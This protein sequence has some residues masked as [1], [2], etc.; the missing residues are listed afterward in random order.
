MSVHEEELRPLSGA[1]EGIWFAQRL[2][3]ANGAYNTGEYVEIHGRIDPALFET[4]LR[5]TVAEAQTF[6][7]RFRD[8]PDG[9]C[10]VLPAEPADWP[11]HRVD[12]SAEPDP[13]AAAEEWIRADLAAAVDL[14]SGPLFT[15][16]LFTLGADHYA[17]S[18]RAHHILLDGYS[19]KLVARRLAETYS[20]L[21]AGGEVPPDPFGPIGPLLEADAEYRSSERFARHRAYWTDRLADA[22]A[23]VRLSGRTAPPVHSFRRRATVLPD[24][25]GLAAAAG[26]FGASRTDLLVAAVAAYLHRATGAED[27]VLGLATMSRL[28]SAALRTPGTTS[29]ILPLRV[30]VSPG[31]TV[32]DLVRGVAAEL[33]ALRRNQLYRG[34]Y[35]RRDLGLLDGGRR[36]YGPVVNLI[37]FSEDLRF[38]GHPSTS[39]HLTG[40]AVEDLQINVRPAEDGPGLWLAFD[41]NPAAYTEQELTA[42]Q[43]RFVHLLD[44]LATAEPGLPLARTSLLLPHEHR[45]LPE[46]APAPPLPAALTA[47]ARGTLPARFEEQAARAPQAPAVTDEHATLTYAELNDRA[48]RLARLLAA[49]GAGPGRLVALALPRTAELVTAVLAVLKTGAGYLPL[50]PAQPAERLRLVTEDAA[51]LLTV[52]DVGS[53]GKLPADGPVPVVLGAPAAEREL[54][55][56]SPADLTDA[57]RTAPLTPDTVAYVI[58]TSGSTGRPKG[59][60]VPHGNVLRLFAAAGDFAF[61]PEDVWTLFHSYAFDFSVWE[62]WGA[63]LHGGRLVV[64]PYA[65]SRAPGDFLEL[66]R[67]ERVTVLNQTPSAFHQ[68]VRADQEAPAGAAPLA[69]R[70]V[71]FGGEALEAAHLRPW[72]DRHGDRGP[73]L[74]NMYGI[75]ETTV[76]VTHHRVTREAVEEPNSRGTIGVPLADLRVYVLDHCLQ[77]VPP[78]TVG[79]MYVAGPGLALGYLDRPGLTAQRFVA[80]P[81]GAPGSRMYRTGD[82]ARRAGDGTLEYRGRADQQVKIR[83]FR[84]EPG[85]I[86]A[87]LVAH[88]A[89]AQAAVVARDLGGDRVLVA[90][91]VPAPAERPDPA[92]LRAHLAGLLPEHL[93]P[94]A[95][96]LLEALPLTG[97]GKLDAAALPAPDFAAAAGGRAPDTAEQALV[98]RLFEEVLRL[99]EGSVGRDDSFFALGGHSLSATRLLSRLRLETGQ[100]VPVA[101]LFDAPTPA[102]VAGRLTPGGPRSQARPPLAPAGRPEL[103]PLSHGQESMW[104]L[105]RIDASGATY[106]IPLV[107]PL[108]GGLDV[109]ALRAAL[110]DLAD[111]HESLRTLLTETD[112]RPR[113]RVLPAGER[114]P[115][116]TEVDCPAEEVAAQLTATLRHRF[117]LAGELPLRAWLLGTGRDRV[118][119]LVLHHSAGDGWSLR[120]LADDLSAAYAARLAGRGPGWRPLPVQ[121]ADYALWQRRLLAPPPAGTGLLEQQLTF[122]RQALAGLPEDAGLPADRPRGTRPGD[123]AA[124]TLTVDAGLHRALLRQAEDGEASLFMVLQA[125]LG[126][127]LTRWGAGPVVAIGTPVAGRTDPAL[128]D[129]VGLLTNTLVLP[130]DASGDPDFRTLLA[131]VR[132]VDLAA[133]DHQDVPFPLLVEALNPPRHPARHPLFQVMLALQNA[134]EA[135]LRL[136]PTTAPLR[137]TATGTAKFDLFLDVVE[138]TDEQGAPAG[139]DCHLEYATELFDAPTA[140][141]LAQ[142]LHRLLTAVAADPAQR[143]GALPAPPSPHGAADPAP[144]G[145]DPAA[146]ERA[147]LA[148]GGLRAAAAVR[149]PDGRP[150]LFAVPARAGAAEQTARALG[151]DARLTVVGALPYDADGALD[152]AA[153]T[154][155]PPLDRVTAEQWQRALA[156]LPGVRAATVDLEDAPEELGTRRP[157]A[158]RRRPAAERPAGAAA[159]ADTPLAVS[160]GPELPEPTV[161]SWAAALRRAAAAGEHA[162]VVHVRADGSETRRSYASLVPEASRV[163]GGL[164][165]LGLR[166]GD[167]VI[168]QCEDTEDYLAALWGCILGGITAVP[169]TVPASY[170]AAS[171]ALTKLEGIWRMLGTPPVVTTTA[172]EPGLRGLAERR[173]WPELRLATVDAL[174]RGPEDRDWY[175]AQPDDLLLM[176]MTSGSTGLPKAVR[177]THRNV[178][179]RSAAA[180]VTNDLSAADVS[181]NWIPLDHVTGVVMFHLRDVYLTCRQVHAPTGWLLQDPLR[182]V[183]LADRHRVS[184]TWAPNFAFGL[185]AEHADRMAGRRWDLSPMRLVMNAGEVVVAAT[186]RGFLHVLRPFGL[187]QDVMHPGWGMSETCSVVT[188]VSLPGEPTGADESFVSCGR[189]YPGFAM[190]IVDGTDRVLREGEVGRFQVRGTSVTS[191]YHDNAKANAESF[192]A[193]G[194]FDTGDLAFLRDGELYIT[195]RAKDVIIVN[196]VNH[197]SHEIEACVE[198]LAT[199]VRSFT[200]AVAVRPDP[201]A[202]TDELALFVHLADGVDAAAALREIRGK[203]TRE[204]G[205]SPAHLLPVPAAAIPKTEIGKIQRTRLRKR[206]EAGEFDE[207]LRQAEELLGTAATVPDWFLR[208]VWQ[209]ARPHR[210]PGGA[211]GH[212]LVLAGRG[213]RAGAVAERVAAG[214]RAADGRCTVVTAGPGFERADAAR[215]RVRPDHEPDLARLLDRLA[216]DG[217][218][219]DA[220]L[221]LGALDGADREPDSVAELVEAQRDGAQSLLALARALAARA[222]Q[223]TAPLPLLF[224]TAGAQPV[225]AAERGGYLHAAAGGLLRTLREELPWLGAVHVDLAADVDAGAA[226][227]VLLTELALPP[228]EPEVAHRSGVRHLRRLAPLPEQPPAEQRSAEQPPA[229]GQ[230]ADPE[231]PGFVLVSGGLGGVGTELAA[232]LLRTTGT[233]LLLVGRTAL[234]DGSDLEREPATG[235]PAAD[236]AEAYRRLR[237]MG[238]IRYEVA[239]VTDP[240][241]LRAAVDR[242]RDAWSAPLAGVL[243]LAGD[244]DE[245]PVTELDPERW[246]AALAAKV[247]GGWVLHRL[248]AELDASYTA[249]SSVNGFFGGSLNA[250]YAAGCAFLDALAV[251]HGRDGRPVR[252]LAWSAWKGRGMSEG[253]RLAALTEARGYRALDPVAAL[254]SYDLAAASAE[255][256]LLIGADRTAP[257]VRAHLAGPARPVQRLAGRVV[258]A[259]GTDLGAVCAGAGEAAR[260]LDVDGHWVLRAA[261][262]AEPGAAGAPDGAADAADRLEG[263]IAG[264]WAGLLGRERIG[265]EENFF[266]LGGSSLLLVA[267][268]AGVNE[269][270]GTDLTVVDLF[271]HPTVRD[272]ARHLATTGMRTADGTSPADPGVPEPDAAGRPAEPTAPSAASAL[273]RARRQNQRRRTAQAARRTTAQQ[274]G[275]NH[276]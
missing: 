169:L 113:Q 194:W 129:L 179:T 64:V 43:Q 86:E 183:D 238:E 208:P 172:G 216:Q 24:A 140:E 191:G 58:H 112:G 73:E 28:G 49:R 55:V 265:R 220:V 85:E 120:P 267:A 262:S 48:N 134:G 26:R 23:P 59:V 233:R 67:R 63:L 255:P 65:V 152:T 167:R 205:V 92:A 236:R 30:A 90:Y 118:L 128:D 51:P 165:A 105:N 37:P 250:A 222:E 256:H 35:L 204:I 209:P 110:A 68:L 91:A 60:P 144:P 228:G 184:V 151:T 122:W 181:L 93:V 263:T 42:H 164:R 95:C 32:G 123:G 41:A 39:H 224:A 175:R 15:H 25:E 229:A 212:T 36:L 269:A 166:P 192:T 276:G 173:G 131:R 193:D 159:T 87:A 22:P 274:K 47:A 148:T 44:Q 235:G 72:L 121:Y 188:D 9:P 182:W 81:F 234:P 187:P 89:V 185:L 200:A 29:D 3:P 71:V 254:R 111:R 10:C 124:R 248:A 189:P 100:Q 158:A 157:A 273:D 177:L 136:G 83:G 104:F 135:V 252:S 242:A 17:W 12:L 94:A 53:A 210:A 38:G 79:E 247:E 154:G 84:I 27:L 211:P 109:G 70:Y 232:H 246:R 119:V 244:R 50:D 249:F 20:A 1:Q 145:P 57:D 230:G 8:T 153:L 243:H 218:R 78:G 259:D 62:L 6:A 217:R 141:G 264:I 180:A 226:A 178:L 75:T 11:L 150:R 190:R 52:T 221:H 115:Q 80:D 117:D 149:E 223:R 253:Y 103:L 69:L 74:V 142:A 258:L 132:A 225:L 54:A 186:A 138:R 147:A 203:V 102:G 126:A 99:P 227:G 272:L 21:A 163:L 215:Y 271:G 213:E 261:G 195:G 33:A 16:A 275:D 88:P 170:E 45:Q 2:D 245:A 98:C 116:L 240:V 198:E 137:P 260:T 155:L 176:L 66:L 13:R 107:V 4:A 251:R 207:V 266:D 106:N 160:T 270:L 161:D 146:L 34:E 196:G 31:T 143:L 168:L 257:W 214:L 268:Q 40:G 133:Y 162:E 201:A 241:Q 96:V 206:F 101:A 14:E 199:V 5:R 239:D 56:L 197:Y 125:A 77:P 156:A 19:Y 108:A 61:G 130:T 76:H 237:A 171:A 7:L 139:L 97:N 46:L 114:A 231:A 202:G 82:L 18:L 219:V 174:R 127:L